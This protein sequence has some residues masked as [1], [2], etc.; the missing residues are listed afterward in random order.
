[1]KPFM[2]SHVQAYDMF[3]LK[4]IVTFTAKEGCACVMLL[5]ERR[6][7]KPWSQTMHLPNIHRNIVCDR[8]ACNGSSVESPTCAVLT[9][10]G[11]YQAVKGIPKTKLHII[12]CSVALYVRGLWNATELAVRGPIES[13]HL[14]PEIRPVEC[15]PSREAVFHFIRH[16]KD[17]KVAQVRF[18][19][20]LNR[21]CA[22]CHVCVGVFVPSCPG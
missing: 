2:S 13:K 14:A 17:F 11:L 12:L 20:W 18:S 10:L 22:C 6:F 21:S 19:Q 8:G 4:S 5:Y 3:A 7:C 15:M 1:M 16:S 9:R